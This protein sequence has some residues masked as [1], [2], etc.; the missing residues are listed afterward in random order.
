MKILQHIILIN[1]YFRNHPNAHGRLKEKNGMMPQLPNDTRCNSQ[2][3]CLQTY[4]SNH[5]Q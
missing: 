4:I 3:T 5:E 1:K 2:R